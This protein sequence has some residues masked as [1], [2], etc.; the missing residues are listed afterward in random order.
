MHGARRRRG[1]TFSGVSVGSKSCCTAVSVFS[2]LLLVVQY[3]V[4]ILV[5][6]EEASLMVHV[7]AVC[8]N[9]AAF[10]MQV[11]FFM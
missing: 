4:V 3:S 1:L 11:R 8:R 5:S 9:V 7:P 6:K 10:D 2:L